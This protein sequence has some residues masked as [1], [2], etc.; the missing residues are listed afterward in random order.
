MLVVVRLSCRDL[1]E[2]RRTTIGSA[3]GGVGFV[4]AMC[5]LSSISPVEVCSCFRGG[6]ALPFSWSGFVLYVEACKNI[7]ATA[8]VRQFCASFVWD[9]LEA[10]FFFC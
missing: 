1:S 2:S 7:I 8:V 6:L 3:A 9:V 4:N 5:L 10:M